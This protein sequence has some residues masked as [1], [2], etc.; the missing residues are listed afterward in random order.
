MCGRWDQRRLSVS[1]SWTAKV[2]LT[3][4][5]PIELVD[6][7]IY[8]CL[9]RTRKRQRELQKDSDSDQPTMSRVASGIPGETKWRSA[10]SKRAC[11][12]ASKSSR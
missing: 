6:P 9:F 11:N 8:D 5:E 4:A 1:G 3:A 2:Q 10:S 7:E 12:S